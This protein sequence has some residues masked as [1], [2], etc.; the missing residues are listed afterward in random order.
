MSWCFTLTLKLIL[1]ICIYTDASKSDYKIVVKWYAD[2]FYWRYKG[3]SNIQKLYKLSDFSDLGI[4]NLET[5]F[6]YAINFNQNI[7]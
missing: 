5:A 1:K 6:I 4:T 2:A 7:N 3:W